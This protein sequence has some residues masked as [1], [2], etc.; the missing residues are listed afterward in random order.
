MDFSP[1]TEQ[2]VKLDDQLSK[3]FTNQEF[4]DVTLACDEKQFPCHKGTLLLIFKASFFP[5]QISTKSSGNERVF[6]DVL[7]R[8][9]FEMRGWVGT[10]KIFSV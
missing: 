4:S 10:E 1:V 5:S 8:Q 7:I 2:P 3:A 9:V 6:Q